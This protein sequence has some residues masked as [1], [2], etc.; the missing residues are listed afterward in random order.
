MTFALLRLLF[1]ATGQ[2]NQAPDAV[3]H[4]SLDE[5]TDGVRRPRDGEVW[6]IADVR[7]RNA[8]EHGFPR[9]LIVPVERRIGLP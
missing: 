2:E 1:S 6:G 7:R 4:G 9:A 8:I 3:L 5:G